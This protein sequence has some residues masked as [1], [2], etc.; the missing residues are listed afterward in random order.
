MDIC[1]TCNH[2]DRGIKKDGDG[3]FL[4]FYKYGCY[5]HHTGFTKFITNDEELMK[6]GCEK[7]HA[8]SEEKAGNKDKIEEYAYDLVEKYNQWEELYKYGS[9]DPNWSD[10]IVLNTVRNHI[11]A[12]KLRIES[13]LLEE[14]YPEIYF[15]PNPVEQNRDFMVNPGEIIAAARVVLNNYRSNSDYRWLTEHKIELSEED[16]KRKYIDSVL[17]HVIRLEEAFVKKDVLYLRRHIKANDY[18]DALSICRI[19][20]E[21]YLN[22]C[23]VKEESQKKVISLKLKAEQIP[24]QISLE[25]LLIS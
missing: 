11:I 22:E 18:L 4:H 1:G 20:S 7:W 5:Q 3:Y 6:I 12:I 21:R 17:G 19:T 24:G 25:E 9:G 2:L 16:K 14:D 15:R 13:M 10:G 8:A 23:K